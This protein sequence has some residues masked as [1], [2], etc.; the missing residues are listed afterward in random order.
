K[1]EHR[2]AKHANHIRNSTND[3]EAYA[4]KTY[5]YTTTTGSLLVNGLLCSVRSGGNT[6]GIFRSQFAY[7]HIRTI[8]LSNMRWHTLCT[9]NGR[10]PAAEMSRIRVLVAA[11]AC[12]SYSHRRNHKGTSTKGCVIL[13]SYTQLPMCKLFQ[14][15][16]H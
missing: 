7:Y 2:M 15:F 6:D 9:H 13:I 1:R 4:K 8:T 12:A 11:I 10:N 16:L 5:E 3:C 14:R